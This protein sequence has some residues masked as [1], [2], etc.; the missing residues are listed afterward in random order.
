[1]LKLD[2]QYEK[3]PT[4]PGVECQCCPRVKR[5][6]VT[7]ARRDDILGT[8]ARQINEEQLIFLFFLFCFI[9]EST[10]RSK[11]SNVRPRIKSDL[12]IITSFTVVE[13]GNSVSRGIVLR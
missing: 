1:M 3:Y 2:K 6:N 4:I 5:Y 11:S 10:A 9:V 12:R 7:I 13:L 8:V